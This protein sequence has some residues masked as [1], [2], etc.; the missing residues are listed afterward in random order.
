MIDLLPSQTSRWQ[1]IEELARDHFRRA[2][3][4]EIRTPILEQTELFARGIGEGTDVVGKEMYSFFDRGNRSCTLRPEGTASVVR[5]VIQNGLASQG[6]QRL[7]YGGPM[8][9]YERPQAGRQ[10]QFHQLGVEFFGLSSERS[11]AEIISIGWDFLNELGLNGL[12]LELNSLGTMEDRK[13]YRIHLIEWLENI[14]D[15]LDEESLNQLKKNPLRILDSKR[16]DIQR[17]LKGAPLLGDYLSEESK[18]RFLKVQE[19]L[20][21][22]K[23]PFV[24]NQRL[25]RGLD[26]YCHT[27][28]E[29]TSNQLG[30]QATVCG[31]G[32]YDGLVEQL[33]GPPTPSIGWAIGIERLLILLGEDFDQNLSPDVYLVNRGEKAE[34][35]ALCLARY[36]RLERFVVE[37]DNSGS[38]FSK[39]FKRASR[40]CASWAIVIG[41]EESINGEVR[42]KRL[43]LK[44]EDRSE[45][46]V[47]SSELSRIIELIKS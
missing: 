42:M 15:S 31:G 23:I 35:E 26:Y 47:K 19:N 16:P 32:R 22:L 34:I 45:I 38:T 44:N 27:A 43:N 11:D 28:F 2:G 1:K 20:K 46:L 3:L 39:Q 18:E 25:V 4:N 5:S 21:I 17:K 13:E 7:W 40:S 12:T 8:F 14:S 9:R 30:A 6:F 41:D 33:G 10:R 36:L 29:I 37:L 24:V